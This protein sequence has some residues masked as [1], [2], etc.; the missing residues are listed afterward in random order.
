MQQVAPGSSAQAAFRRRRPAFDRKALAPRPPNADSA[1]IDTDSNTAKEPTM[2]TSLPA[3]THASRLNAL[4]AAFVVTLTM[5]ASIDRLADADRA[6]LLA[7]AA[8]AERA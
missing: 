7:G 3:P 2:H 5:L 6:P 4:A 1:A 8:A